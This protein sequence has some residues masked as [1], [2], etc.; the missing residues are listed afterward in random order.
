[1]D[2]SEGHH[3]CEAGARGD[4]QQQQPNC[5]VTDTGGVKAIGFH[6]PSAE[7]P[8][9][10]HEDEARVATGDQASRVRE[11]SPG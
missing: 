6:Q 1:M 3:G 8:S 9:N 4:M 2:C 5:C 7:N 10:P 11:E